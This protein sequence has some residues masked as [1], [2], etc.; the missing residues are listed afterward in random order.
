MGATSKR[1]G[2]GGE[3]EVAKLLSEALGGSFI[4]SNSSG[5]F[6]GGKNA[7]RKDHLSDAQIRNAKGDICPPDHLPRLIVECKKY[8]SFRYHQLL[9]ECPMLDGWLEQ[10]I[11]SADAKDFWV[12]TFK[13]DR[14]PWTLA[15]D[16]TLADR[17]T[18]GSHSIYVNKSGT[19]TLVDLL[20]FLRSNKAPIITLASSGR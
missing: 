12:L 20:D 9:R 1:K 3:R 11:S 14:I 2:N 5:A 15:F 10:A 16:S 4:R 6:I 18:L 8:A 7:Q 17:F 13:S 19:Y